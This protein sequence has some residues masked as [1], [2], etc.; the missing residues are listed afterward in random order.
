MCTKVDVWSFDL[1]G[2]KKDVNLIL[3]IYFIYPVYQIW[4]FPGGPVVKTLFQIYQV[5]V[6]SLPGELRSHMPCS[7]T[8]PKKCHGFNLQSIK[9]WSTR[10]FTSG[11]SLMSGCVSPSQP[12]GFGPDVSWALEL[13]GLGEEEGLLRMESWPAFLVGGHHTASPIPAMGVSPSLCQRAPLFKTHSW[14]PAAFFRSATFSMKDSEAPG[15][16]D[17]LV[18]TGK[19][20]MP[21]SNG[22][23]GHD[24]TFGCWVLSQRFHSPLS[25]SPRGSLVPLSFLPWGWWCL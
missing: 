7:P 6:W 5:Q 22:T 16:S 23:R 3:W 4:N 11:R 25:P 24:L 15:T 19:F 8:P 12:T 14:N 13:T 2:K 18:L 17:S 10:G 20:A 1:K 9:K 21:W